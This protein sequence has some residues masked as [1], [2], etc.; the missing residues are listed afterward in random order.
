M[1]SLPG[2]QIHPPAPIL[3]SRD[4]TPLCQCE[5]RQQTRRNT[6]TSSPLKNTLSSDP[7][8]VMIDHTRIWLR[9]DQ[10]WPLARARMRWQNPS[11]PCLAGILPQEST[12]LMW[13]IRQTRL[14]SSWRCSHTH[15]H[16]HTH[17]CNHNTAHWWGV[18][19]KGKGK[20]V[21]QRMFVM[22]LSV[23]YTGLDCGTA[24]FKDQMYMK[25]MTSYN[26]Y[27]VI[28]HIASLISYSSLC[29]RNSCK[30]S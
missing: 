16:T 20:V 4:K 17:G 29:L 3:S 7:K 10:K 28:L 19:R 11:T 26:I 24:A 5:V 13:V 12:G 23:H 8:W 25:K 1:R 27:T 22:I 21:H 18:E 30:S 6:A 14:V 9:W 2:I 15:T